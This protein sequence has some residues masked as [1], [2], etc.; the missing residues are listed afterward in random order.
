M[1]AVTTTLIVGAA[2]FTAG[3]LVFAAIAAFGAAADAV[4]ENNVGFAIDVGMFDGGAVIAGIGLILAGLAAL[5]A[6]K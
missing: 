4:K 5:A 2:V 3:G 1:K 6:K